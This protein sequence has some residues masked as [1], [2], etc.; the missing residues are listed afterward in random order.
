[1]VNGFCHPLAAAVD[2]A[3]ECGNPQLKFCDRER[4]EILPN[5]L[6]QRIVGL[7]GEKI[8][9]LHGLKVDPDGTHVNKPMVNRASA[10]P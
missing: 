5:Q 4:V 2:L 10:A 9:G 8:V 7:F 1:M 3:R 6:A